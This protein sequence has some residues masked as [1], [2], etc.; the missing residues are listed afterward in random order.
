MV[1]RN[2]ERRWG[3]GFFIGFLVMAGLAWLPSFAGATTSLGEDIEVQAWYR[4]RN[5]FQTD[6]K[7]H[8]DW[9]QWRNEA[10]V[11]LTY[12]N[13]VENGQL[14]PLSGLAIP[15]VQNAGISARFRARVDPV[16]YLRDHYRKLY[17]AHNRSDFFSPEKEFRDLYI[18]MKHGEVGPGKLS[19]RIGYQQI[20]WGESDLFRSLDIINPLRID[21]NFPIGEKFDEFR[22]PILAVKFLY[23]IGN[24]GTMLSDTAIEAYYTPR[25]RTVATHLI[26]EG[27]FRIPVQERG[28]LGANGKLLDYTPENCAHASKFLPYR[29]FWLG[30]RRIQNP[31]SLSRAGNNARIDPID[32]VCNNQRCAPDVPG[33]RT[34]LIINLPKGKFHH[35][36]RGTD[37]GQWSAAGVRFL[38]KTVVGVDWSL[39]YLFQPNVFADTNPHHPFSIYGDGVPGA[40]G[41]FEEGLLRC[42]SPTGK[43]GVGRNGQTNGGAI[44]LVG[45]DLGGYNWPERRLDS[46]GNPL[47]TAKQKQAART[48]STICANGFSHKHLW[49]HIIG[50]TGTYNDF[51][52][53]GAV[54]RMEESLST[55]EGLNK[56]AIG[57]GKTFTVPPAVQANYKARGDRIMVD[58]MVW[59]SMLGFD[60]VSALGNYRPFA[61]TRH[62]PGDFG[63]QQSFFT[64]QWLMMHNFQNLT[65]NMCN[66]NFAL[67]IGEKGTGCRPYR[68]N[69]FFTFAWAGN[70][71]F[72]GKLEQRA[73]IA[74]EPRGQAWLLYGQWWWR[75]FMDTPVDLSFG[76]SWFPSSRMDNSWTL[77]NYFVHRNLLWVEGTY[78]I[79]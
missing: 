46:K 67:G 63:T 35:H 30:N 5:T 42:L 41:T 23:D 40:A 13:M 43:Q 3:L 6:G 2:R 24:I 48:N 62:L 18:D 21:Q 29:P 31:W 4:V 68:W 69:H 65:N 33:D 39:D 12:D 19:T 66:W 10:F 54:F 51:D 74:L 32:Y 76:T 17:D 14:K 9:V 47:P 27:I 34:T 37:P 79:L 22:L 20:V 44:L 11:W 49:S 55:K 36:S 16:Y 70:G 56:R 57:Y 73:A 1:E 77:L 52:Y 61:W 60:L 53:T 38:A 25:F 50:L 26:D 58:T 59:R 75:S 78:Y 15:F 28:C 64:F 45:G 7:D 72:H 71:F 8:F